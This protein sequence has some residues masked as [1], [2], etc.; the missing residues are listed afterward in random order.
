[1]SRHP[2]YVDPDAQV[3]ALLREHHEARGA[4]FADKHNLRCGVEIT[5]CLTCDAGGL[6]PSKSTGEMV[7]CPSCDG[8]RYRAV[9]L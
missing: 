1:M 2:D 6:I 9:G 3:D 7:V 4:E 5:P 8:E